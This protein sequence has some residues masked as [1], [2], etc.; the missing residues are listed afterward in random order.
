MV[1]PVWRP[2]ASALDGHRW[3]RHRHPRQPT[4]DR[5]PF[6]GCSRPLLVQPRHRCRRWGWRPTPFGWCPRAHHPRLGL[7]ARRRP[8]GAGMHWHPRDSGACPA[9]AM[10]RKGRPRVH[11]GKDLS[12]RL[13]RRPHHRKVL[14]LPLLV[15]AFPRGW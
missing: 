11:G 10:V 7:S 15:L 13:R 14:A 1:R 9:V 3:C 5:Q 4:D 6:V 12:E 8:L 2:R